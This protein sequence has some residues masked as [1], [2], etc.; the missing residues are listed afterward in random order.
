MADSISRRMFPRRTAALAL[1][2]LSTGVAVSGCGKAGANKAQVREG[3]DVIVDGVGYN[4]GITRQLNITEPPDNDFYQ[5]PDAGKGFAL[6]GVFLTA[7][8]VTKHTT[9][10]PVKKFIIEDTRGNEYRPVQLPVSNR[11]AFKPRPL[12]YKE[13]EPTPGSAGSFNPTGGAMLL[14]KL[15]VSAQENRPLELQIVGTHDLLS[16]TQQQKTIELDI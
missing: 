14:F 6:Y 10:V 11:F 2:L 1:L 16:G 15:P 5:G 7:C 12:G 13:C 4:V 8:N 3:L 9:K